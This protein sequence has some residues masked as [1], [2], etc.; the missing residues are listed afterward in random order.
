MLKEIGKIS[1]MVKE[2]TAQLLVGPLA[3]VVLIPIVSKADLAFSPPKC[4]VGRVKER[5]PMLPMR[6]CTMS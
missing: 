1:R 6:R 4:P 5:G 3:V 2:L